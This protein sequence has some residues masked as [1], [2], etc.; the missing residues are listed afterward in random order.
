MTVRDLPGPVGLAKAACLTKKPLNTQ[1]AKRRGNRKGRLSH[2]WNTGSHTSPGG[3]P[4]PWRT[5][6]R[7]EVRPEFWKLR[8]EIV[9]T[10]QAGALG[11]QLLPAELPRPQGRAELGR[12][13]LP[14]RGP[15]AGEGRR[16]RL[17]PRFAQ[18]VTGSILRG[19]L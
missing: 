8:R 3:P 15:S 19:P 10:E 17:E 4:S 16:A 6:R 5:G 9:E 7:G 11:S 12:E 1:G 13:P 14:T 2:L 18:V